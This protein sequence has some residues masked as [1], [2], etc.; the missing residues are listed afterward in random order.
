MDKE[1]Q[2]LVSVI[3]PAYNS[4]KYIGQAIESV[5]KQE[6]GFIVELIVIND[7]SS[8]HTR[9]AVQNA[10]QRLEQNHTGST[11]SC[12]LVYIEN[13]N[14]QGVAESRNIGIRKANGK[15]LAFLDADDW[16]SLDKLKK[17]VELMERTDAVLC[18][19]GR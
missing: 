3:M 7:A 6:G 9:D 19:T 13:K 15:Y 2:P 5:F 8:D 18:G 16:W 17:Q 10:V 11:G 14:N 12:T 1:E 4:E